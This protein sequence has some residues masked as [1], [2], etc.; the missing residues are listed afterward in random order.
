MNPARDYRQLL[1]A[2]KRQ[3]ADKYGIRRMGIFG[4][5]ARYV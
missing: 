1:E 5:V 2:Y 3:H 4:S